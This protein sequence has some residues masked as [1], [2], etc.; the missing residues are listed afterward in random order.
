MSQIRVD[1]E[2]GCG[3]QLFQFFAA[4]SIA[5]SKDVSLAVNTLKVDQNRHRGFSISQS[6]YLRNLTGVKFVSEQSPK[7]N[8]FR[9]KMSI[10]LGTTYRPNEIGMPKN[11]PNVKRVRRVSGYFQT[12]SFFRQLLNEELISLEALKHDFESSSDMSHF[13]EIDFG[14]SILLHMRGGDYRKQKN[15][16]GCLSIDYFMESLLIFGHEGK[17]VYVISDDPEK[18]IANKVANKFPY[19]YLE[20]ENLHPLAVIFLISKFS[21]LVISNSTL[22]FWGALMQDRNQ[23]IAPKPWYKGLPE[24]VGLIPELWE[25]NC[26]IWEN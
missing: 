13:S 12:E 14:N 9:K 24:P 8:R 21:T 22:S 19:K 7:S 18:I 15:S 2:G 20:T 10:Y 16:I 5:R 11:S 4:Y 3:N 26:S 17:Q 1:L 23:V 6:S 25:K